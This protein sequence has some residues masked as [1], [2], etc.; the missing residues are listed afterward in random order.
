ME[1]ITQGIQRPVK[2]KEEDRSCHSMITLG[3][4]PGCREIVCWDL[5]KT[6]HNGERLFMKWSTHGSRKTE[7]QQWVEFVTRTAG[8]RTQL[9][10]DTGCSG[11]LESYTSFNWMQPSSAQ[12][13]NGDEHNEPLMSMQNFLLYLNSEYQ[14]GHQFTHCRISKGTKT[15]II[16]NLLSRLFCTLWVP[17][18]RQNNETSRQQNR[19]YSKCVGDAW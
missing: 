3:S 6:E 11:W 19:C 8:I 7:Q 9:V 2:G 15:A 10:K 13:A 12:M 14:C 1:K 16:C 4:G 5:S 17:C 18:Q